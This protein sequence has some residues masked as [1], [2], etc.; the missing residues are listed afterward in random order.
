MV[1]ARLDLQECPGAL[2]LPTRTGLLEGGG[3]VWLVLVG[4]PD[5]GGGTVAVAGGAP[6]GV[7]TAVGVG[8]VYA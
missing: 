2:G 8:P 6:T 3:T 1:R 4:P 7:P 5:A